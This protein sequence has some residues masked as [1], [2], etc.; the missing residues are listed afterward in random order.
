MAKYGTEA[1]VHRNSNLTFRSQRIALA[2]A[3]T[4]GLVDGLITFTKHTLWFLN[5]SITCEKSK[6]TLLRFIQ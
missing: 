2:C 6:F 4:T 5:G 1:Y 3:P